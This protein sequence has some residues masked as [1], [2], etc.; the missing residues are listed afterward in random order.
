LL[1]DR[2]NGGQRDAC[3]ADVRALAVQGAVTE[4]GLHLV[5][6]GAGALAALLATHRGQGEVNRLRTGEQVGSAVRAGCDTGTTAD[7]G[8]VVQSLLCLGVVDQQIVGVRCG[9]SLDGDEAALL[10]DA[11]QCG[12]VDDHVL[13]DRVGS[14][15]QRLQLDGVTIVEGDQALLAGRLVLV[16][17]VRTVVHHQATGTT[18]TVAAVRG[19]GNDRKS[20]VYG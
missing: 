6:H 10:H 9:T 12:T 3:R 17:A 14:G 16:W 2:G 13:D 18:D 5:D 15:A 4:V 11:V 20:V 8:R 19:K 1:R 7:A